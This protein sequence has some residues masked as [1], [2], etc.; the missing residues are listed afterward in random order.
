MTCLTI[1][2]SVALQV[3]I[4]RPSFAIASTDTQIMQ[5]VELANKEGKS[6]ASRIDWTALQAEATFTTLATESQGSLATIASGLKY[7]INDTIWNR[8]LRRP[9]FGPKTPQTWQQ[10][11]ASGINGPWSSFRIRGGTLRMNPVPTAGQSCYFEYASKNWVTK[12][13]D[14]TGTN[15]WSADGDTSVLDED[16]LTLGTLWRWKQAKGFDYA[17]D[18][19]EYERQVL[20]AI[21]R[22]GSKDTLN[23]SNTRYDVFPG[24][25]VPSGSWNL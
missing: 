8:T 12:A 21:G 17:E 3:G 11:V 24:I 18:F 20:D 9:V 5:L 13:S 15:A 23:L 25:V 1:I 2:Q 19:N 7:I 6:L 16:L 10:Q 4:T 22:D 14:A